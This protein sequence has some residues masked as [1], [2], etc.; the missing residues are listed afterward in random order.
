MLKFLVIGAY[1]AISSL[2]AAT[3]CAEIPP[4]HPSPRAEPTT[5]KAHAHYDMGKKLFGLQQFEQ[6]IDEY[7]TGALLE[8][9]PVWDLLLGQCYRKLHRHQETLW[10]FERFLKLGHPTGKLL[11]GVNAAIAEAHA[12]LDKEAESQPPPM[13]SNT[14]QPP[15]PATPVPMAPTVVDSGAPWYR[16]AIGMT[17]VGVGGIAIGTA[18]YLA[19]DGRRLRDE[20]NSDPSHMRRDELYAQSVSRYQ[21]STAF[22]IGG[23]ITTLAGVVRFATRPAAHRTTMSWNVGIVGNG[24]MLFGRF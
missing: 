6:A 24:V 5:P 21:W 11:E 10:Y 15:S 9:L 7:K 8:T 23:A 16:D 18:G 13:P 20:S 22:G 3:T 19:L 1:V 12:E 4:I 14:P 2:D 17:L